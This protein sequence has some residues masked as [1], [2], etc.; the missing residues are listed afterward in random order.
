MRNS[1]WLALFILLF[2]FPIA[3]SQAA[4]TLPA[5][6]RL[7]T[8]GIFAGYSN[9]SSHILLGLAQNRKL[10]DIGGSYSRRVLLNH[11]VDGQYML[12][13]DPVMLESD[14][15]L[16]ETL[17]ITS[18]PPVQTF[19]N[20]SVDSQACHPFSQTFTDVTEGVTYS[21]TIS[22]TCGQRHWTFGEGFSPLGFK[23]NF[24]PRRRIQP[25]VTVLGGYMFS[26]RRIPVSDASSANFTLSIGAGF[27]FYRSATRS[28]RAEYR[29]H[30]I[31]NAGTAH[32]NPGIDNQLIQVSYVF[33]H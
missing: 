32:E 25:V 29:Y 11:I 10:L 6:T 14:P 9:N 33:G 26:T 2:F 13:L 23:W 18:P 15:V 31:S 24:L 28:I 5:Y 20:T 7:N 1:R 19:T 12:E 22:I 30:H 8:F 4:P 21:E 17:K 3:F 16:Q 27:E